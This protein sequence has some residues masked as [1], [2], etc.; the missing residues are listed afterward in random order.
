MFL[1]LLKRKIPENPNCTKEGVRGKNMLKSLLLKH[2]LLN[3]IWIKFC[4][5]EKVWLRSSCID[6][7]GHRKWRTKAR[8]ISH[9]Y[10]QF[11]W[12]S[13]SLLMYLTSIVREENK[14]TFSDI[15]LN[16]QIAILT[17][18][19]HPT[20]NAIH[21]ELAGHFQSQQHGPKTVVHFEYLFSIN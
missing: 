14:N 4:Q 11:F 5:D 10:N 12:W 20:L 17:R 6:L 2:Y 9:V 18:E 1:C 19:K 3:S 13:S 15:W 21:F 7:T 16:K 8:V